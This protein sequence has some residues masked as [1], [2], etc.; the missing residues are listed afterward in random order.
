MYM[1]AEALLEALLFIYQTVIKHFSKLLLHTAVSSHKATKSVAKVITAVT[2][3]IMSRKSSLVEKL[4]TFVVW[5]HLTMCMKE[6]VN[7][8]RNEKTELTTTYSHTVTFKQT[9][10]WSDYIYIKT[11]LYMFG[12]LEC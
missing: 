3:I 10:S 8:E 9:L 5:G 6:G 2:L 7:D 4:G 11:L 12:A 1:I